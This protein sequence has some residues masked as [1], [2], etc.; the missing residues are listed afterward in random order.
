MLYF[1]IQT[2]LAVNLTLEDQD[3]PYPGVV[4]KYYRASSP[5]TDV[6]V[7]EIDLCS[8]GIHIDATSIGDSRQ[9]TGSWGQEQGMQV[10]INA[11]FYRSYPTRVYGDAIGNGVPWPLINTG[12]DSSYINEWYYH[13]FGWIAF[14]HDWTEYS[15]TEWVKQNPQ[16]FPTLGG[17]EPTTVPPTSPDGTIALISG[18]P[19]LVIEGQVYTCSSPTDSTCFP[20]R[21]DMR[22]RNPRS[23]VGLSQDKTT[24]YLVAVDGRSSSNS[25]MYGSELAE[26]MGLLG[27]YFA[28]NIDGGASTQ[29]WSENDGY[30]NS[31]SETYR[32]VANHLGVFAGTLSGMPQRP[33]HCNEEPPCELIPREG[34]IID[35]T[36]SCFKLFGP[37][38]YWRTESSGYNGS[39]HWT[40]A[41]TQST[42]ANWAWWQLYLEEAGEYLVEWYA[43][44]EYAIH[45][46]TGYQVLA[47][48]VVYEPTIDQSQGNGWTAL[49]TY[50]FS[51]GG[52]QHIAVYDIG[53]SNTPSNQHIVADAIRLTRVG[54]WCGNAT[55]DAE[56]DCFNCSEDCPPTT[57]IPE[58]GLDDDCDGTVDNDIETEP[59]SEPSSES[60]DCLG[61]YQMCVD[62]SLLV[63]CDNGVYEEL[64]CTTIDQ[65]CSVTL[66]SCVDPEC[67]GVENE[68][69][70]DGNTVLGCIEGEKFSEN[71]DECED[72]SCIDVEETE[73]KV[74]GCAGIGLSPL[75]VL[76]FLPF[77]RKD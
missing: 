36:S 38:Q 68:Q 21:T 20:D 39:L 51:Q 5:N 44:P 71:C 54:E 29:L 46:Q 27:A 61:T 56:E 49:G 60:S 52:R 32:S 10:A 67:I 75:L 7:A 73:S 43:T 19:S 65:L 50:D 4:I 45:Q 34:G 64:D 3:T 37:S 69:Y 76:L 30:L 70:C 31:P 24:L 15:Y 22:S 14:G 55:C 63:S 53:N 8:N 47:D 2:A 62:A 42:P 11:D 41:Y 18:F 35:D 9:P 12:L 57:E 28:L 25:G 26:T 40:N 13:R 74:T 17:W 59:S 1:L 16:G 58:N 23:A 6:T 48:E 66:N 77:N 72:G 33:G